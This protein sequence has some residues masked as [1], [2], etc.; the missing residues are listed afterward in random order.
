MRKSL[1]ETRLHSV[2]R[3][4]LF[5]SVERLLAAGAEVNVVA[6]EQDLTPLM[7]ACSLGK[8]KGS[9]IAL[10]LIEAG[11]DVKYVRRS[12]GM[13]ALKFA[14]CSCTAE[15]IKSLIEHGAKVDGPKTDVQTA[16]MLAAS[17]GN[18]EALKVLI[19][20]GADPARKC[21][22]KWAEG[23]TAEGLA[24]LQRRKSAVRFLQRVRLSKSRHDGAAK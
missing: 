13:T 1:I 3:L 24:E 16:L 10:R 19:E 4:G 12:D 8:A 9:R 18:V 5:S 14:A 21:G 6:K 2:A 23:R 22:L 15:V 11:A 20:Y 17:E 7:V